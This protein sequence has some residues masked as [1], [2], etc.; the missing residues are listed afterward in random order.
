MLVYVEKDYLCG[1]VVF[2][3]LLRG[4][5]TVLRIIIVEIYV[6]LAGDISEGD[7]AAV[8]VGGGITPKHSSLPYNREI[9]H[10]LTRNKNLLKGKRKQSPLA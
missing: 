8:C 7:G 10:L 3:F 9:P 6:T 1:D 5:R 4:R 2:L